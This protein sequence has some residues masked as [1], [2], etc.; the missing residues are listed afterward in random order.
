[1]P[2]SRL[3]LVRA[4]VAISVVV[5]AA[6]P[7]LPAAPAERPSGEAAKR[8]SPSLTVSAEAPVDPAAA[9]TQPVAWYHD[10]SLQRF[11]LLV[12]GAQRGRL[13]LLLATCAASLYACTDRLLL[14]LVLFVAGSI[15][16]ALQLRSAI[17]VHD[18]LHYL[19]LLLRRHVLQ[20]QALHL[21]LHVG[22]LQ[23][24]RALIGCT[25]STAWVRML[26]LLLLLPPGSSVPRLQLHTPR[27]VHDIL[28]VLHL[29]LHGTEL[30][31]Q[32]L[33]AIEAL[34]LLLA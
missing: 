10:L 2:I 11:H 15:H 27:C 24:W 7:V 33:D 1:M 16:T 4:V 25:G 3:R 20:L 34:M 12:Q 26:L 9:G 8:Q 19:H 17:Q 29:L 23:R 5:A 31:L 30:L 13:Q 28:Q 21:L 32:L 6:A 22:V 14:T 18:T